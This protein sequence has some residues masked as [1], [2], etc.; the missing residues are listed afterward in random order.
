VIAIVCAA[1]FLVALFLIKNG[2]LFRQ[3]TALQKLSEEKGLTYDSATV[4]DLVENDADGDGVADWEEALWNLDPTKQETVPGTP[5]IATVN[6]MKGEEGSGGEGGGEPENLTETDKFSRELFS[7]LVALNQAGTIDQN[8]VDEIS[9]SLAE[10]IQ[11]SPQRK[12]YTL[13]D[14][15]TTKDESTASVKRYYDTLNNIYKYYPVSGDVVDILQKFVLDEN[16]TDE[17]I[18]SKLHPITSQLRARIDG[19]LKIEVPQSLSALYLNLIN[20]GEGLMENLED[21]QLYETDP[22]VALGGMT[23]YEQNTPVLEEAV[24]QLMTAVSQ[25]LKN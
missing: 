19:M 13:A 14:L 17:N 21:I 3:K 10:H 5:D 1:L 15:K 4:A 6:K 22:I 7:S 16:N 25:K 18:L 8:T 9:S 23:K 12:I 24:T 11:N 2:F 20:T